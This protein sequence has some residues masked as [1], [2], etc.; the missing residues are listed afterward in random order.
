[1]M[2]DSLFIDSGLSVNFW[3]EAIDT[4]NYLPN[5]LSTRRNDSVFISEKAWTGTRQDLEHVQIFGSRVSTF[6]PTEKRT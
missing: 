6:I 5:R 3:A 2:K 1:M 4:S